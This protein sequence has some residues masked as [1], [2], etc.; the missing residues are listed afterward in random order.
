[1]AQKFRHR[2]VVVVTTAMKG[3]KKVQRF[4]SYERR[5]DAETYCYRLNKGGPI[6][7]TALVAD[8]ESE[9]IS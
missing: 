4:R 6:N 7:E 8:T 9:Q 2:F 3:G 1:M 5:V